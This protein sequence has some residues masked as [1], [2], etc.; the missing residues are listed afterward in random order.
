ML[1]PLSV[2]AAVILVAVVTVIVLVQTRDVARLTVMAVGGVVAVG[3]EVATNIS[4]EIQVCVLARHLV[5]TV[6]LVLVVLIHVTR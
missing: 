3:K 4:L 5:V 1:L 2:A 6:T